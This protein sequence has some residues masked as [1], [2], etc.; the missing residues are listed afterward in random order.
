MYFSKQSENKAYLLGFYAAD[1]CVYKNNNSI[2]LTLASVDRDF[3]EKIKQE[4]EADF[5]IR[6]YETKQGYKNSEFIFTSFG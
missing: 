5:P 3:L 6:D 1:G 2:K 4:L